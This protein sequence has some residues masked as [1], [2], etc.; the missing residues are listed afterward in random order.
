MTPLGDRE[1]LKRF[2]TKV[3]PPLAALY[4]GLVSEDEGESRRAQ[5]RGA[6]VC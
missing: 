4:P 3:P 5:E 2:L 1:V 6:D